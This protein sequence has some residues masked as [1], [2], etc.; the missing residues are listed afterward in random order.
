MAVLL[1]AVEALSDPALGVWNWNLFALLDLPV[2][3]AFNAFTTRS[4]YAHPGPHEAWT[5]NAAAW[6]AAVGAVQWG[7]IGAII[8]AVADMRLRASARRVDPGLQDR[9]PNT[10]SVSSGCGIIFASTVAS[11]GIVALIL[12]PRAMAKAHAWRVAEVETYLGWIREWVNEYAREHEGEFPTSMRDLG[13][14]GIGP[15]GSYFPYDP[16]GNL[17][18]LEVSANSAQPPTVVCLGR[19]GLP[20]GEGFDADLGR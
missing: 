4:I 9:R 14:D 6:Y 15:G 8:G 13:D 11:L 7:G 5:W 19:D 1:I 20:G 16:W 10:R 2:D 17:Y 12:V 18:V 3:Q